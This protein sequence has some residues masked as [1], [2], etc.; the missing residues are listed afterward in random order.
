MARISGVSIGF[1]CENQRLVGSLCNVHCQTTV[2]SSSQKG[3]VLTSNTVHYVVFS[4]RLVHH[5]LVSYN[6][7]NTTTTPRR[8]R[9]AQPHPKHTLQLRLGVASIPHQVPPGQVP[10]VTELV[11]AVLCLVTPRLCS[12]LLLRSAVMMCATTTESTQRRRLS[13]PRHKGADKE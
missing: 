2:S 12:F 6:A 11:A 13:L 5:S 4:S 8:S 7:S 10:I 1:V 9:L 3:H